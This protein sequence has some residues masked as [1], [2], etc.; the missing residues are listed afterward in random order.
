MHIEKKKLMDIKD[1]Y[2]AETLILGNTRYYAVASEM[3]GEGAFLINSETLNVTPFWTD[4]SGVM[5]II[6]LPFSDNVLCIDKFYPVFQSK[7]AEISILS[8]SGNEYGTT[9]SRKSIKKLPFCHR[10]GI[11]RGKEDNFLIACTLCEDK[12][13]QD[14]WSKPGSVFVAS[15]SDSLRTG[16][17]DFLRICD[18]LVKNHGLYIDNNHVY[19]ASEK[20]IIY[21]DFSSYWFGKNIKPEIISTVPTSD[22]CICS[23]GKRKIMATIEPFHGD[24]ISVYELYDGTVKSM[25]TTGI[26]FGHVIWCGKVLGEFCVIAGSRGGEKRLELY[27]IDGKLKAVIDDNVGPT[28]ISVFSICDDETFILSANHGIG[29]VALYSIRR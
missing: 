5:N 18:G 3:K 24:R 10:I 1:V 25:W 27:G 20:G 11:V 23:L 12:K 9:W 16:E 15:I 29:E 21:L 6:Q 22:L 13:F 17:W 4:E 7:E 19:I 2:V 26:S 8:P 28:Q 14:D